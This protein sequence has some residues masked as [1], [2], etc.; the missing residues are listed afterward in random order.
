MQ[1]QAILIAA[2]F[3]FGGAAFAQQI[4]FQL[5][6]GEPLRGL[7]PAQTTAFLNGRTEFDTVLT[8][9]DGLGPIF[10]DS[11]CSQCHSSPD[12]GGF[13][14]TFVT[15]FGKAAVGGSPFD[16]LDSQGG[17]LL[18]EDGIGGPCIEIVPAEADVVVSRTTPHIFGSGLLEAIVDQD[19]IDLENTPPHGSVSGFA[20]MVAP[21]EGGPMR[22]GRMGWKGGVATLFTFSADASLNEMGLTSPFFPN[23]NAP[24][25]DASLL[26][27]PSNCDTVADPEDPTLDRINRQ[28]DFQLFLAPPPQTPKSGMLG[29]SLFNAVGCNACHVESFTTAG[30]SEGV[31]NG[32]VIR[33]YSD[34]LLHDMG[35]DALSGGDGCG[36]GIVEGMATEQEMLTRALWGLGQRGGFLHDGRATGGTFADN[37]DAAVQD[38]GGEAAFSRTA[39]NALTPT[40]KGQLHDFLASLGRA[41]FDE[42]NN[43][44]VDVFDWF[45][46]S[47]DFTGPTPTTPI[48]PDDHGAVADVDQDADFDM[49]DFLVMQRAF[50][51]Q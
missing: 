34:F 25:G 44:T 33:P 35:L 19:I 16:P 41:E 45:F 47:S 9:A 20:H 29:E 7:S 13:S 23:E 38:H 40:E 30:H 31:L 26:G 51:G 17:S 46:L 15:R 39:Y 10:N 12:I 32:H 8:I 37:I 22:P 4:D 11:S 50:T 2:G 18:Q 21:I 24:N 3:A 27:P 49:V 6:M 28:T 43:N 14:T 5:R 36:D 48:L 42:D 1:R